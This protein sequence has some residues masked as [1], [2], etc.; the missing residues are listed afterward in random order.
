M[1][2]NVRPRAPP[3]RAARRSLAR[4]RAP[5]EHVVA[6]Q[7]LVHARIVEHDDALEDGEEV[8]EVFGGF[9]VLSGREELDELWDVLTRQQQLRHLGPP[10]QRHLAQKLSDGCKVAQLA[11][12]Q[13]DLIGRR[14][15]R[16]AA[17]AGRLRGRLR[18]VRCL[19]R[20]VH[21]RLVCGAAL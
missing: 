12:R 7:Q 16:R 3:R 2:G 4:P 19:A 13:A 18:H 11:R 10:H 15:A 14:R 5:H 9:E 20:F 17:V 6:Q 8:G 1:R 21:R